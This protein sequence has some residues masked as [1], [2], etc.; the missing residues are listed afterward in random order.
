MTMQY[1]VMGNPWV[2]FSIT[3]AG[4]GYKLCSVEVRRAKIWPGKSSRD[5]WNCGSHRQEWYTHTQM[6]DFS[7]NTK[8][9]AGAGCVSS[10]RPDLRGGSSERLIP[11]VTEHGGRRA[12]LRALCEICGRIDEDSNSLIIHYDTAP[13]SSSM[14]CPSIQI[15]FSPFT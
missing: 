13:L 11:T 15:S 3:S 8:P 2:H 10:A 9:K 1:Q 12:F 14:P 5:T 4:H 6:N 7:S